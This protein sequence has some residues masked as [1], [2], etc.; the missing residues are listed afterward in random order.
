MRFFFRLNLNHIRSAQKSEWHCPL[1]GQR[2]FP[3]RLN[4]RFYKFIFCVFAFISGY[5][6]NVK[7]HKMSTG[8]NLIENNRFLW[9]AKESLNHFTIPFADIRQIAHSCPVNRTGQNVNFSQLDLPLAFTIMARA[10]NERGTLLFLLNSMHWM[11]QV[12]TM[13]QMEIETRN[14]N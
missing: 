4:A 11:K 13:R 14:R 2:W 1:F 8:K 3:F 7:C 9:K 5:M 10:L 12:W 6:H